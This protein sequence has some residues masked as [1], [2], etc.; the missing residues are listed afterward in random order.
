[1]VQFEYSF[2]E[3]KI[4]K[5][6]ARYYVYTKLISMSEKLLQRKDSL[7]QSFAPKKTFKISASYTMELVYLFFRWANVFLVAFSNEYLGI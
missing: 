7:S 3:F 1:M 6:N 5:D 2:F 4:Q